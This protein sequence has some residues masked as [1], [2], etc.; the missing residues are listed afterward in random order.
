MKFDEKKTGRMMR[1]IGGIGD[2][3]ITEAANDPGKK[4]NA[5]VRASRK[6]ILVALIAAVLL[7]A[8]LVTGVAAVF[9]NRKPEDYRDIG[10]DAIPLSGEA[11]K[12]DAVADL[13]DPLKEV[14]ITAN[15]TTDRLIEPDSVFRIETAQDCD[16][17]LLAEYLSVSPET[18]VSL[19]K[20]D[21][22]LF[23][24]SP[25]AGKFD[26]GA[27]YR[28]TVGD[29]ANPAIS[30]AFQTVAD[31]DVKSFLP[32]DR[33]T[34]APVDTGI[35]ITFTEVL[36]NV[37]FDRYVKVSP[38][39][40]GNFYLY[41]DG[42]TL[43]FVPS[44]S[45]EKSTVYTVTAE[46]GLPARSGAVLKEARSVR[47]RTCDTEESDSSYGKSSFFTVSFSRMSEIPDYAL[48]NAFGSA[49]A[50]RFAPGKD[51]V[52]PC[53]FRFNDIEG[54]LT[55]LSTLYRF[56]SYEYALEV[57]RDHEEHAGEQWYDG[58]SY[59][60]SKLEKITEI[61]NT[62]STKDGE[63]R[64]LMNTLVNFGTDLKSGIYLLKLD[65]TL[66][67]GLIS[68][69]HRLTAYTYIQISALNA[70]T[71][72]VDGKALVFVTDLSGN[73]VPDASLSGY[74]YKAQNYWNADNTEN[75]SKIV[76]VTDRQGVAV[77]DTQNNNAALILVKK[78]EDELLLSFS[79][80]E[81]HGD[82]ILL[83]YM[84]TDR[85]VYF[86]SD[87]VNFFGFL[88]AANGG[89]LP[90]KLYVKAG[91]S[92][93]RQPVTVSDD[94][95]FSGSFSYEKSGRYGVSLCIVDDND[96]T[97]CAHYVRITDEEKPVVKATVSFDAPFGSY[98]ETL[99]G[100][101]KASYF[102]GT[103]A[104]GLT[105]DFRY[106]VGTTSSTPHV[107]NDGITDK[108][109][110]ISFSISA[111]IP[112]AYGTDPLELW[113][114]AELVGFETQ[115]LTVGAHLPYFHS[116]YVYA[117]ARESDGIVLTLNK[118]DLSGFPDNTVGKAASGSVTVSLIKTTTVKKEIKKYDPFNKRKYTTWSYSSFNSTE[119]TENVS[120]VNGKARLSYVESSDPYVRYSYAVEYSDGHQTYS[121]RYDASSGNAYNSE[122]RDRLSV[123]TDKNAY[124]YGDN[125]EVKAYDYGTAAAN[126]LYIF[127]GADGIIGYTVGNGA[128]G[129]IEEK[130]LPRTDVTVYYPDKETGFYLKG[131]AKLSYDYAN[132]AKAVIEV[133]ADKAVY[134]PGEKATI[135]IKA[136]PSSS[137][138]N[139]LVSIVDEACFALGEQNVNILSSLFSSYSHSALTDAPRLPAAVGMSY[140]DYRIG[141]KTVGKSLFP[142]YRYSS[143]TNGDLS[144]REAEDAPQ[145]GA[146]EGLAIE[147]NGSETSFYL[148]EIFKD[149]PEFRL[150]PLNA[151]G[152]G[153][154]I[155]T[156]PDNM[157][158]WRIT[159]CGV[160]GSGERL[161]DL[162]AGNAS[163]D[164]ICTL[165]FYLSVSVPSVFV[166]GDDVSFLIKA[167]GTVDGNVSCRAELRD[168]NDA[169]V[170][171]ENAEFAPG[172]RAF[173]NLGKIGEGQYSLCVFAQCAEN[174]D[175]LRTKFSVVTSAAA[176][177]VRKEVTPDGI[178]ELK[179]VLFPVT[180]TFYDANA[181][182]SLFAVVS[183]YLRY[184]NSERTDVLAAKYFTAAANGKLFSDNETYEV[185]ELS[186]ALK[187]RARILLPLFPYGEVDAE[188]T[189]RILSV[190]ASLF[191][192]YAKERMVSAYS[193]K[194]NGGKKI[195]A[196]ELC[197][198]VAALA[199]LGEPVLGTA[200]SVAESAGNF[201][202]EAKLYLAMAFASLGDYGSA[203]EVLDHVF[204]QCGKVNE[205]Y[206]T[207]FLQADSRDEEIFL[208]ELALIAAARA[209]KKSAELMARFITTNMTDSERGLIGL[210]SYLTHFLN[211]ADTEEKK[212][213]YQIGGEE[214]TVAVR[215]MRRVTV[216]LDKKEF[217][218]FKVTSF[219][220]G[221]AVCAAY[222]GTLEDAKSAGDAA[223]R[224]NIEKTVKQTGENV[225]T[226]RLKIK[227][228]S[229]RVCESFGIEDFIPAG[230]RYLTIE[231][232]RSG[233][234][235]SSTGYGAPIRIYCG[236]Y[237]SSGQN[238]RGYL[239]VYNKDAHDRGYKNDCPDY[240]FEIEVSYRIR[241]AVPGEFIVESAVIRD[242][243]GNY[244]TSERSSFVI[245]NL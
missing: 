163:S 217:D 38:K 56:P 192:D 23:E 28:L 26:R 139:I 135:R 75:F 234:S 130:M 153:V 221:I 10:K 61:E 11:Q 214:K 88:V 174:T 9:A 178:G 3:L 183:R 59:D 79:S 39:T 207:A 68:G 128:N 31:F 175:A 179:P 216:V 4:T 33:V 57:A 18:D 149:N 195:S 213:T 220:S 206:G 40:S 111:G 165:P 101:L 200:L 35:E 129:V 64:Y 196:V 162:R 41:P 27:L 71:P 184:L 224:L 185:K 14:K 176:A 238:M 204:G 205:T 16:A 106:Y 51:A 160:H 158:A 127:S 60:L 62:A 93:I 109:G 6:R 124:L 141:D 171:T 7:V 45:L 30:Y 122:Y 155:F 194:L 225:Y 150:V 154:L 114:W 189:A 180:L 243:A 123:K 107:E 173:I 121:Y 239:S 145:P 191:D 202:T 67:A 138:T 84:Y 222:T 182:F 54:D 24:L 108:N 115:T 82:E 177:S 212:I 231:T 229:N 161:S 25:A 89:Q 70:V 21:E 132:A 245:V 42:K 73:P 105:F 137:L 34:N 233:G 133:T 97:V 208:T 90:E 236:M 92:G 209:D 48:C 13:P 63:S 198:S 187:D 168:E 29:P 156:V 32:A 94:G 126:T 91:T 119:K 152:E 2:D 147:E 235:H 110:E 134:R 181:S 76:S 193:S 148:R 241:G 80:K 102:D 96:R 151:K 19:R 58:Y 226:V 44:A 37:D 240:D 203:K 112:K 188:L 100:K 66:S 169:V 131:N 5:P 20:L 228:T 142:L 103:P 74:A 227:G 86:Q 36:E 22:R 199:A 17:G 65:A 223:N 201:P 104:Q 232:Q 12:S 215:G 218:A 81:E 190:D 87:T 186:E 117:S 159:C 136:D 77:V 211:V 143:G 242:A 237:S 50:Y 95:S 47:F 164:V 113:L 99:T 8:V 166:K 197:S 15:G 146:A 83:R 69:K 55:V 53:C 230:A 167:V 144:N 157:T 172:Q 52:I 85:E 125:Y 49:L 210:A 219:D 72:S 78:G 140:A 116:D 244:A 118:R 46:A 43:A 1:S 170:K 98:R 120:F